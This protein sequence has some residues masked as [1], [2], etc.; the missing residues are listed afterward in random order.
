MIAR[1][2]VFMMLLFSQMVLSAE[3]PD[4]R[5]VWEYNC[6]ESLAGTP[7]FYPSV[8]APQS[9]IILTASGKMIMVDQQG[10]ETWRHDFAEPVMATPAVGEIDGDGFQEII[11]ATVAGEVVVLSGSG[12]EKWR[13]QLAGRIIDWSSP[14]LADLDGDGNYEILIGD[15]AGWMNCLSG[16]G[17]RLW[18]VKADAHTTSTPAIVP[19]ADG[20]VRT[21]IYG[22]ENDH[23]IALDAG[24][25]LRWL[26]REEGQ[27]GR[28]NPTVGD[29]DGDGYY[30]V[31][32]H[33]SFNN[34]NSRLLALDT[35]DG[36]VLWQAKLNLHGYVSNAIADIDGDGQN[37]VLVA[38]RSNTIY[39]FDG[40][41]RERWHTV[42]G[43]NAFFW[44]PAVADINGDGRCEIIAGVRGINERGKSWFVLD[45]QGQLLGEYEMPGGA[46]A[47]PLVADLDRNRQIDIILPGSDK[48]LLRCLTF[49]GPAQ[50]ARLEWVSHRYDAARSG[51]KPAG[52]ISEKAPVVKKPPLNLETRWMKNP[53]WGKNTLQISLPLIKSRRMVI[54]AV[55]ENPYGSREIML[56]DADSTDYPDEIEVELAAA[57]QHQLTI[58]VWNPSDW[59]SPIAVWKDKCVLGSLVKYTKMLQQKLDLLQET[60]RRTLPSSPALSQMLQERFAQRQGGL[61]QL[62]NRFYSADFSQAPTAAAFLEADHE[63]NH[64]IEQDIVL[65]EI[66]GQAI[67]GNQ[68]TLA[69]WEDPNP[70]NE[71]TTEFEPQRISGTISVR[72]PLYRSEYESRA[73]TL[74][75]LRP[76]SMDV[77]IR[78]DSESR[79]SVQVY[80]ILTVPRQDGTWVGDALA[81]L[82]S[83]QT[84]H[85]AAGERRQLWLTVFGDST[86]GGMLPAVLELVPL[87][88]E[89]NKITLNIDRQIIPLDLRSAPPFYVCN[90]SSPQ[91]LEQAGI[92]PPRI[93]KAR[94]HG[95]NVF[96]LGLPPCQAD[97]QGELPGKTDWTIFDRHL[98]LLDNECFLLI[99]G[100]EIPIPEKV[101]R[102]GAVHV[103]AQQKWFAEIRNHLQEKGWGI[104]RWALYPVDEPGLFGGTLIRRFLEIGRHF[105]QAMP[106][107]PIYANPAGFVTTENMRE[108]VPLVDVWSPEQALMRRQPELAPFFLGTGKRVWSY[109]APP[110][111]K[112]LYPL[113]YYRANTWM[114]F[115]LGLSGTGFW[116]Q[117]YGDLWLKKTVVDY[118]AN[119]V[120]GTHEII[121]RRWEAFRDGIEDVR[122]FCLLQQTID[123]AKAAGRSADLV[124]A[125]EELLKSD[126]AAVTKTAWAANDITRFLRDYEMDYS[127][128]L[129]IRKR[130]AALTL[131]LRK[132]N[133]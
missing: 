122:A 25:E 108:M 66:A 18:R 48:G 5:I 128:I 53:D 84:V 73:I 33:T 132:H 28:T 103:M 76:E 113:G 112:T 98:A 12:E 58:R 21:I 62:F 37:E 56:Y 72:I 64:L 115:Q 74:V 90:W 24:G 61:Q 68:P 51:Y 109:E 95:I 29:L 52:I 86:D 7:V 2:I 81:E 125:A 67:R 9:V 119:Y 46:N 50:A 44:T 91:M 124:S 3:L 116:T 20:S 40:N 70:W 35:E 120:S 85:L 102:F 43:G 111:V 57:G 17:R 65:A 38:L 118:G 89:E 94:A 41:G 54:E 87:G 27:Y 121:S 13:I 6:G 23:L 10:K 131:Q 80:E 11:T 69:A 4:P 75:N 110:E 71:K 93:C 79:R 30:E 114:A 15:E 19:R 127:K 96:V 99:P 101:E 60:A 104:E 100:G 92:D 8:T 123:K 78:K 34:P 22:N 126:I 63:F 130:V 49:D 88:W 129:D 42:T 45:D 47:T 133:Q 16:D 83:A 31:I 55:Q 26:T 97:E 106:D 117:F 105:K 59:R 39:C 14:C 1:Y 107:V 32:V 77:Q 36:K 82:N